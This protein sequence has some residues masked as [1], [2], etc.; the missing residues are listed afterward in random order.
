ML[1]ESMHLQVMCR[2]FCKKFYNHTG[3]VLNRFSKDIGFLDDEIPFYFSLY[4][5]VSQLVA[6]I[7][8]VIFQS[9]YLFVSVPL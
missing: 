4:S 5:I 8:F 2:C 7:N 1:S 6:L 9:R 3:R